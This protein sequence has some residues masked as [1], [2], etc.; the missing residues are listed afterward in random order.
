MRWTSWGSPYLAGSMKFWSRMRFGSCATTDTP[1][2]P[3]ADSW[4]SS[5]RSAASGISVRISIASWPTR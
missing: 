5:T 4:I 2:R 3:R 1:M